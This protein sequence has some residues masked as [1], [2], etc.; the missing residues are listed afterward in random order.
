[1][2][3]PPAM[4]HHLCGLL[5]ILGLCWG[6]R[7]A[8]IGSVSSTIQTNTA[9][10]ST[11]SPVVQA[12][13]ADLPT[14][15]N[16]KASIAQMLARVA[17]IRELTIRHEVE[18]R[19]LSRQDMVARV[20]EQIRAQVPE[21]ALLGQKEL[22]F[23]LGTVPEGFDYTK[24]LLQLMGDQLAGYY[25]PEDQSMVLAQDLSTSEGTATLAHELVHALQ[26]QHFGLLP[27]TQ[28]REDAGDEE[29]AV[30]CLAEGDATSA[31]FDF[32]QGAP[33]AEAP[34][35]SLRFL[36]RSSAELGSGVGIPSIVKRSV[37]ASYDDGLGL[38][39]WARR[40]GGWQAVDDL[41]KRL[42]RSTEQVLHPEKWL[43]DEAP[44]AIEI[45]GNPTAS[46]FHDVMGEQALRIVF[47]EWMPRRAAIEAAQ[48]WG[49]DR[50][51]IV[52]DNGG[53][54]LIWRIRWDS[55][56]GASLGAVA[57][58]R[59]ALR[60]E[61]A[62]GDSEGLDV[63][64]EEAQAALR[65]GELCRERR[66][67]GPFALVHRNR[68]LVLVAGPSKALGEGRRGTSDCATALNVARSQFVSVASVAPG[69]QSPP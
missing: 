35:A 60:P 30:H 9:K 45:P 3:K 17:E 10:E 26:D 21:N 57:F 40:R 47:E 20:A 28:F 53:L 4:R 36:I 66:L 55:S 68:E 31:M 7:T 18:G 33:S 2:N 67:R 14:P 48:G 23:A 29:G 32:V 5:T 50:F 37:A 62:A 8:G 15:P 6:C 64:R 61:S 1:M 54:S 49:G 39:N 56:L 24:S 69:P 42:P 51:S 12:H 19:W 25:D 43:S 38:V 46:K 65:G 22:L 52:Q 11:R 41:W 63:S 44:E 27:H 58:A 34:D 13:S 16:M 59:G